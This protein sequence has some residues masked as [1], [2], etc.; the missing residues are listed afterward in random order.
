V[1]SALTIAAD[2][3]AGKN[4]TITGDVAYLTPSNPDIAPD[5]G[6]NLVAGIMGL[7]ANKIRVGTAAGANVRIDGLVMAG[8][9]ARNDGGFGADSYDSR[10]PGT[11]KINGGLIQKVRSPVGMF[12]GST[13]VSG[14]IKD[15]YYDERMMDTPPPFFPTTGK[16]DMLSWKQK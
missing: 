7:Y 1:K 5:Q 14:F 4:M 12:S 11:L 16:Y 3:A 2:A 6:V 9:S 15:Y 13:Q 8:S 10:S